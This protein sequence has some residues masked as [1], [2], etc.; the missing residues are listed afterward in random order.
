MDKITLNEILNMLGWTEA[1]IEKIYY[2]KSHACRCGCC[3]NYFRPGER[4]FNRHMNSLRRGVLKAHE[5][6]LF[7]IDVACYINIDL[8]YTN[9][10]C[11][12]LYRKA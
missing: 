3:G 4:G 10:R 9:D 8:A 6:E 2:G 11:I 7:D 5:F 12:C 1:D